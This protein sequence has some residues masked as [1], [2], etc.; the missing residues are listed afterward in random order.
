MAEEKPPLR[1]HE[2]RSAKAGNSHELFRATDPLGFEITLHLDTWEKHILVGHPE[3]AELLDLV[4]KTIVE[5]EVI[6]QSPRQPTTHYYYR[7]A[8]RRVLRQDDLFVIV[9][10]SRDDESKT[11]FIKTAHLV[12][13]LREGGNIL[14]FKRS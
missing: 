10:A 13:K 12:D 1:R 3:M 8:G 5:P 11:G 4:K 2:E 14:W 9:V 7:L 6:Q